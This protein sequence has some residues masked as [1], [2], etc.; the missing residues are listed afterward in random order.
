MRTVSIH[1]T[2][3]LAFLFLAAL[4][5]CSVVDSSN[6]ATADIHARYE[7]STQGDGWSTV[8]AWLSDGT[9]LD[10]PDIDLAPS[11][12]LT[13]YINGIERTLRKK[14]LL[15]VIHY[16]TPIN[17]SRINAQFV[18]ALMREER[19][20]APSSTV[21][22]PAPYT[23][24]V[25]NADLVANQNLDVSWSPAL[26]DGYTM[27]VTWELACGSETEFGFT[28]SVE[29]DG[30]HTVKVSDMLTLF[31]TT[32]SGVCEGFVTLERRQFGDVDPNLDRGSKIESIQHRTV[33]FTVSN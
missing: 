19:V 28:V 29:D 7:V 13:V 1:L 10:A 25:V 23:A 27:D 8:K 6:I 3:L 4:S 20:S 26:G 2:A 24:S 11:D 18:V 14:R 30:D 22:L 32:P 31:E 12:T 5:G 16:E 9:G 17:S 21:M 33:N 15:G